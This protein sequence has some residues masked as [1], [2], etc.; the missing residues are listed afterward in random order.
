MFKSRT[1]VGIICLAL[2]F[3]LFFAVAPALSGASA[4]TAEEIYA[5]EYIPRGRLIE[6]GML[7]KRTVRG[8]VPGALGDLSAA[9]GKYA[10]VDIV[11]GDC[12]LPAKLT[13][14]ASGAADVLGSLRDGEYAVTL[15]I[16]SFSGAFSGQLENGDVLRI[17]V[18]GDGGAYV[19]D[20]LNFVRVI[21]T[22]TSDGTV[23]DNM[24][25]RDPDGNPLP[26]SVMFLV[27]DR[28]AA[29]L[30]SFDNKVRYNCAFVCHGTDRR[31][32]GYLERQRQMLSKIGEPNG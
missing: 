5:S 1:A 30:F 10:A 24:S 18:N 32:E 22:V 6:E 21:S 13:D 26:A 31:A 3:I 12:I 9:V 23:R 8:G 19:P 4:G 7:K 25:M 14:R 11:E 29:L 20:E 28:Q 17:Y 27:C 16:S 2:S 15:E